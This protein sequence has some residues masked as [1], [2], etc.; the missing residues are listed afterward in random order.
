V[1]EW[2]LDSPR[3]LAAISGQLTPPQFSTAIEVPGSVDGSNPMDVTKAQSV[4]AR[5]RAE[6][7]QAFE[8]GYAAVAVS[9]TATGSSYLLAPWSHF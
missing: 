7:A 5:M 1:A 8:K 3:V 6:F 9:K 2:Y 4:Q